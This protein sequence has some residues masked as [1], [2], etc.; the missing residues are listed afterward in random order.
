MS[1]GVIV[2]VVPRP[3]DTFTRFL[4]ALLAVLVSWL[5]GVLESNNAVPV[6]VDPTEEQDPAPPPEPALED[7]YSDPQEERVKGAMPAWFLGL[8][9]FVRTGLV[10]VLSTLAL[11]LAGIFLEEPS[12]ILKFFVAA[13]YLLIS[14]FLVFYESMFRDALPEG[15]RERWW[16]LR[17]FREGSALHAAQLQS[18]RALMSREEE[19]WFDFKSNVVTV[20]VLCALLAFFALVIFSNLFFVLTLQQGIFG[21]A[22]TAAAAAAVLTIRY[23]C[24]DFGEDPAAAEQ[25]PPETFRDRLATRL[26]REI[27]EH[28]YPVPSEEAFDVILSVGEKLYYAPR[29]T[30]PLLA[31]PRPALEGDE[32]REW[33]AAHARWEEDYALLYE[34][35]VRSMGAYISRLP[36]FAGAPFRIPLSETRIDGAALNAVIRPFFFDDRLKARGLAEG[37][38]DAF[39]ENVKDYTYSGKVKNPTDPIYPQDYKGK[40]DEIV[41]TYL[42]NTALKPLYDVLVPYNPFTE[43]NRCAHHWCLGKTRRGKTTFLRHLIKHDLDEVAKGNCSLVVIDG[44][45]KGLVS[46]M[47]ALKRF[48]PGEDLDG[49]LILIDGDAPFPLNPFA[50]RDKAL[51]RSLVSYMVATEG[52]E[53][54]LG[55]LSHFVDAVL[56]GRDK[57]LDTLI[58]YLRTDRAAPPPPGIDDELREWWTHERAGLHALTISGVQQRLANFLRENRGSP[59]LKNLRAASWGGE[60]EKGGKQFSFFDELHGGGKVLLV[61]T[62]VQGR[63]GAVG[64]SLMGRLFI[65]LME[66]IARKR[67]KASKPIWVVIDEASDYLTKN[68]PHFTQIL[69]KAAGAKVGMTVAYQYKGQIDPAIEKALENAEIHSLFEQRGMAQL[70]IEERPLFLAISPLEFDHEPHMEGEEYA[71]MRRRLAALYPYKPAAR[72]RDAA[73]GDEPLTQKI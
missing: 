69:A 3:A 72:P 15:K 13:S 71:D 46:E 58:K 40:P 41:E 30:P 60:R 1:I 34:A 24:S 6:D 7:A 73:G 61:D 49:R 12:L 64:G 22:V 5:V 23:V 65:A 67:Q 33:D 31:Q 63:N 19:A 44:K 11:I 29:E 4:I 20:P 9:A 62:E 37:L 26:R 52:S 54:Q 66:D 8:N 21:A 43:L 48:A 27:V 51:A 56:Q 39:F 2:I 70:T 57:S 16:N 42:R 35:V 10:F 32:R 59:I 25:P 14:L 38:R 50:I 36:R 55:A 68:D 17:L 18:K 45:D 53:L 47:R 28:R